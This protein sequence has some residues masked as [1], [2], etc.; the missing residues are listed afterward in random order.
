MSW[1]STLL[2]SL[3]SILFVGCVGVRYGGPD[4]SSYIRPLEDGKHEVFY[5]NGQ[6]KEDFF[7]NEKFIDST[8]KSF[9]RNGQLEYQGFFTKGKE[10]TS[11]TDESAHIIPGS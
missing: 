11:N 7:I 5:K 8:F 1:K 6:L 10:K 4:P 3:V 2:M 9:Y